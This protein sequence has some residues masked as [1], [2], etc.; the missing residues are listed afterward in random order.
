[1]MW[2]ALLLL[3]TTAFAGPVERRQAESTASEAASGVETPS[4][5]DSQEIIT[6]LVTITQLPSETALTVSTE[7]SPTLT[8]GLAGDEA[9]ESS[10]ADEVTAPSS[11]NQGMIMFNPLF[12]SC[13]RSN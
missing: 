9:T 8:Q 5:D 11:S 1:M 2:L 12:F 6:S 7:P 4:L 13:P 3:F 10:D